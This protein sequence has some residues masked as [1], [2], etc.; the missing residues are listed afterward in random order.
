[1]SSDECRRR[2]RRTGATTTAVVAARAAVYSAEQKQS[3]PPFPSVCR[4]VEKYTML[5]ERHRQKQNGLT[6]PGRGKH[7]AGGGPT[8][9]GLAVDGSSSD[10]S[11]LSKSADPSSPALSDDAAAWNR[12]LMNDGDDGDGDD[13]DDDEPSEDAEHHNRRLQRRRG[14]HK[15][16]DQQ[17]QQQPQRLGADDDDYGRRFSCESLGS[18]LPG[19]WCAIVTRATAAAAVGGTGCRSPRASRRPLTRA[20]SPRPTNPTSDGFRRRK[21]VQRYSIVPAN[22]IEKSSFTSLPSCT[23]RYS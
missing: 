19:T 15:Q 6:P 5:I 8:A 10:Y 2:G 21:R 18:I 22:T 7:T 1:M 12:L 13:D 9:A 11:S 23:I 14:H 17:Q 16:Q 4:L 20:F 3:Q